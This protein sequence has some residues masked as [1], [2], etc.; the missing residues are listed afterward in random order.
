[1]LAKPEK[2]K[3][4][5]DVKESNARMRVLLVDVC[6]TAAEALKAAR[7]AESDGERWRHLGAGVGALRSMLRPKPE[8]LS[9]YTEIDYYLRHDERLRWTAE[10]AS[11]SG[12]VSHTP[13]GARE[14]VLS[15]PPMRDLPPGADGVEALAEPI[16][17][18]APKMVRG[19]AVC[20]HRY[21]RVDI[22]RLGPMDFVRQD[23]TDGRVTYTSLADTSG[24]HPQPRLYRMTI[25]PRDG[26]GRVVCIFGTFGELVGKFV[27]TMGTRNDIERAAR[28]LCASIVARAY[29]KRASQARWRANKK[30]RMAA[31]AEQQADYGKAAEPLTPEEEL[32]ETVAGQKEGL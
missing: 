29:H 21:D 2:M 32:A 6:T 12:N 22:Y 31:E 1:M 28:W 17:P 26:G 16:D 14:F 18:K 3:I 15:N 8:T 11:G 25:I 9:F 7:E 27:A 23:N 20:P 10:P 19:E 30:A 13:L 5:G 24:T 4:V